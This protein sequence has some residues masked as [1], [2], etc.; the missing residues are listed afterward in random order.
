MYQIQKKPNKNDLSG[1]VPITT[2][3]SNS[4]YENKKAISSLKD[5][6]IENGIITPD[7]TIINKSDNDSNLL[8][9]QWS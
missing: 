6:L 2:P 9:Q 5:S 1:F 3:M 4:F 8:I 7:L